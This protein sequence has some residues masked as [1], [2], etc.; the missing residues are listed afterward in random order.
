[1][2][3][4]GP[5]GRWRRCFKVDSGLRTLMDFRYQRK[6]KAASGSNGMNKQMT[7]RSAENLVIRVPGGTIVK[8]TETGAVIG[9]LVDNDDTLVIAKGGRG[10]RGNMHFASPKNPAPE[11]A[12]NGEPGQER[13]IQLEL[14]VLGMLGSLPS[15]VENQP[16]C[17]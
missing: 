14:R 11:I 2:P 10:G 17:Q 7:G 4:G 3:N 12:E 13:S 16:Y 1:M 9:D 5:A 6:F 8:N 15:S